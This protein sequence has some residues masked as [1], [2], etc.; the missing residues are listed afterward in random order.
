M[1]T[2]YTTIEK[3]W[4]EEVAF[5]IY[6]NDFQFSNIERFAEVEIRIEFESG[7]FYEPPSAEATI[8]DWEGDEPNEDNEFGFEDDLIEKAFDYIN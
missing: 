7:S 2:E 1:R 4:T 8:I 6:P 5:P 3:E